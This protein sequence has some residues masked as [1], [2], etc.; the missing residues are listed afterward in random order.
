MK[1]LLTSKGPFMRSMIFGI[2]F[3]GCLVPSR[4]NF[5]CT[6]LTLPDLS[7]AVTIRVCNPLV[8]LAVSHGHTQSG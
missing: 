6:V 5:C 4:E 2:R 3:R 1:V 7:V 8:Y